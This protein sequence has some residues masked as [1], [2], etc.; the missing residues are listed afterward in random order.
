MAETLA[1]I[2]LAILVGVPLL[3]GYAQ[4]WEIVVIL[5]GMALLALEIFVIPGFGVTGILGILMVLFGLV[6]TF[7]GKEP[8]PGI[9][10]AARGDVGATS[11]TAWRWS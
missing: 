10:A 2:S 9:L 8:G 3:T 11:A 1:V 4:W 6:M 5:V 7:V